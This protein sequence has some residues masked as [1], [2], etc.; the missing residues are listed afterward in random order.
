[1]HRGRPMGE[2]FDHRPARR[3]R[4]SRKRGIQSIHNRMVVDYRAM[5]SVN[6]AIVTSRK[7]ASIQAVP[8]L[9]SQ[10]PVQY[11]VQNWKCMGS[12]TLPCQFPPHENPACWKIATTPASIF[13]ALPCAFD[14][15]F[16]SSAM[17]QAWVESFDPVRCGRNEKHPPKLLIFDC[18]PA[19]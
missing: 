13:P 19:L 17:P 18:N 8:P 14:S 4:Q 7:G 10:V 12:R 11:P 5:S 9:D 16:R 1:M 3:I 2:S 15:G 6:F